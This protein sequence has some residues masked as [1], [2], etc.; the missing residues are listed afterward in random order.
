M[1]S[2]PELTDAL[3]ETVL[4]QS[5]F[6]S[7][8]QAGDMTVI[9]VALAQR[10]GLLGCLLGQRQRAEQ[11]RG[12]LALRPVPAEH[13]QASRWLW[14]GVALALLGVVLWLAGVQWQKQ[15]KRPSRPALW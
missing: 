10:P 9:P 5:V 7:P 3:Q 6:G 2:E 14:V 11:V 1:S 15:K 13:K 8:L 4:P 12:F